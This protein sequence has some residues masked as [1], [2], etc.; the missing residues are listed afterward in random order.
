MDILILK[1]IINNSHDINSTQSAKKAC[2][3]SL[4]IIKNAGFAKRS[5]KVYYSLCKSMRV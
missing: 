1:R 3:E 5:G 4:S 2:N